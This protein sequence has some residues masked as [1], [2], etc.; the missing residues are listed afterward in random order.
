M[1]EFLK[2]NNNDNERLVLGEKKIEF[3]YIKEKKTTKT[4][5]FNL[6]HYVT[7]PAKLTAI[8]TE[9]KKLMGTSCT[10]KITEFGPGYGFSGDFQA[11]ITQYLINNPISTV[12]VDGFKKK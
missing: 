3:K 2:K 6:E 5:I 10:K 1:D 7:D 11:K 8:L 4:Y 9:L 12:P